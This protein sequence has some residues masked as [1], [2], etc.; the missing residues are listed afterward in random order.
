MAVCM[1]AQLWQGMSGLRAEGGESAVGLS[2]DTET[3]YTRG[4]FH[5]KWILYWL[6]MGEVHCWWCT[7]LSLPWEGTLAR[8]HYFGGRVGNGLCVPA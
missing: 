1:P 6:D 7:C 8:L 4:P 2:Q 5:A 3:L